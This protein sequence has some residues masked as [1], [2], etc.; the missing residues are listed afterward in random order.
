MLQIKR[1]EIQGFKSFADRTELRFQGT[2]FTA[3]V[4]PNG[5]GKS[6]LADA[7]SWVLGEQSAK[8]LRGNRMEDVI[9]AGTRDRKAVGMASVTMTLVDPGGE[10][11]GARQASGSSAPVR[12]TA[13]EP[14]ACTAEET[15]APGPGQRV[16][17]NREPHGNGHANGHANG[18]AG[19]PPAA[20]KAQEITITRRLFRSGESEYLINGKTARLRDIQDLF[21]GTG[22]GPESY[23]I[24]EQGRIT[25]ILSTKPQE[26]RAVIEEAAGVSRF[27]TRRRLAEAKLESAK[28]NLSRVFDILEEVGRQANSLK[29]QAAK[30]KRFEELKTEMLG[31]LRRAL[32]GRHQLRQREAARVALDLNEATRAF[33]A[34]S[35]QVAEG[36]KIQ[37][38][39]QEQ[40]FALERQLTQHR[41]SFSELRV[42]AERLRGKLESQ[43]A[44]VVNIDA[45]LG[46]GETELAEIENRLRALNSEFESSSDLLAELNQKIEQARLRLQQK[47][48]QR[49][50]H[51]A[52]VRQQ[53]QMLEAGRREV[54]RL[55]GEC[56][57]L[58]NQLAQISEYLSGLE[59]E[60][61][62]AEREEKSALVDL[63]R[64]QAS[65]QEV[66][67][68]QA[69]R[70]LEL[71]AVV[72]QRRS[73]E[74][75][76]QAKR[77]S[78]SQVRTRL[79]ELRA[80]LSRLKARLESTRDVLSHRSYTTESVK[81]LFEA[82]E[83]KQAGNLEPLGVLADFLEVDAR[84]EKAT[85][86]FLHEELEYVVVRNWAEAHQGVD[87]MRGDLD[88][89]ATFFV[90]PE[91]ET[92]LAYES[93]REPVIGRDTGVVARLSAQLRLTNGLTQAPVDYIPRLARCFLVEDR[94]AARRLA[95]E[96][97]DL[98]FLLPDGVSY[99]GHAVS[100]GKKTGSGPLALKRELRELTAAV[101][102][103]QSQVEQAAA[104]LEGLEHE[105]Q[106]LTEDLERLRGLQQAQEKDALALDHDMRKLSEELN[107]TN[108]RISVVRLELQRLAAEGEKARQR[109]SA[110]QDQLNAAEQMR[111]SHE[112]AL[113][114][115]RMALAEMQQQSAHF[116]EEHS[117]LR[118]ELAGLEERGRSEQAARA[119]LDAQ[120]RDLAK[121]R[122]ELSLELQRLGVE[123]ARLLAD[124]LEIDG[125]L[126]SYHSEL[127]KLDGQVRKLEAQELEAR[128]ALAQAEESLRSLRAELAAS[129]EARSQLEVQLVKL[130]SELHYL[131]ETCR[132]ELQCGVEDL[133]LDPA[134]TVDE[135]ALAEWEAKYQEV[136]GKIDNLGP[137]NPN[138]LAEFEEAQQRYDFL[139]AQRQDL[140]DSIRDTEKAI[141]EIDTESR[142][143]FSEA[144]EAINRN[145]RELFQTLFQGGVG[146]MRLTDPENPA[147]SGIDIM[148][149]PPG[150]RLQNVLLLS[151]GERSLTAMALLLA[152]FR[153][154]PSPF[155]VLDEV[156]AA[157][158]E[159]NITRLVRL[160]KE[161]SRSTQFIIITHAK[162]TME[163]SEMLYGVTMQEPGVSKIVSVRFG[164]SAPLPAVS[165]SYAMAARAD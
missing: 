71:T 128:Q 64:L 94:D 34:L 19:C 65:C 82:I 24:I 95:L 120:L 150:K 97:P 92:K 9:F 21:L 25:Q 46:Q 76:L 109:Q 117:A 72:E 86:E 22:L 49:D 48:Q 31:H 130:Q 67:Q 70:Q 142:K 124:N 50:Q 23:A 107:R 114:E 47:S 1:L 77:A 108:Q 156:D 144:F 32:A 100:G 52:A 37:A 89:R 4:G 18:V 78:A 75:E 74:E 44:Q 162:R 20:A 38:S 148:A 36:E 16:Q 152:I 10:L 158:D 69:A 129:N 145:F 102:D 146:E 68:R 30:A 165:S 42:E 143:R 159:A 163:A 132:K 160:L 13:D 33:Q 73:A 99:H 125:R 155:C 80:E 127:E 29:R 39:A 133:A 123:R 140:L 161:M 6:N 90:H 12:A 5:C 17:R 7:I 79:E 98:Y 35:Q 122:E 61:A 62:R 54:L 115:A 96:Y 63:E 151:G 2:G 119:R 84:W 137:V 110:M 136:R 105:I 55:L 11:L 59:R 116:A 106:I 138:A 28:Q 134:D 85:E 3:I 104:T 103:K 93:R 14:L 131:A 8:T 153:Y 149:S 66:G 121:Q 147:E 56:S 118:A 81:R 141:E 57:S 83:K 53:E 91:P 111:S 51:Q 45:R 87:L 101:G 43:A 139:N 27:K 154:Q 58:K 26:R 112:A 135:A 60:R 113:E 40:C 41:K 157:L 15:L 126:A 164:Q 88:G